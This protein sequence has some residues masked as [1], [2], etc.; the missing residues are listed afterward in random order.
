MIYKYNSFS[1]IHNL[2]NEFD[3]IFKYCQIKGKYILCSDEIDR[4]G[5]PN[6]R[7]DIKKSN[8]SIKLK[9]EE[10]S[11]T[12]VSILNSTKEIG[13]FSRVMSILSKSIKKG[14]ILIIDSDVS[15]GF[16][17]HIEKKYP[18]YNWKYK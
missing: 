7:I 2:K 17:S 14:S 10:D 12:F 3:K 9:I 4:G 6:V 15:G 16:W 1:A 18:E 5:N 11:V 8:K 13:F